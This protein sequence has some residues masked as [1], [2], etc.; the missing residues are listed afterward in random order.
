MRL[1]KP[2][3]F[4]IL[5]FLTLIAGFLVHRS[6]STSSFL[7]K[8]HFT[9]I[10]RPNLSEFMQQSELLF[11]RAVAKRREIRHL[12]GDRGFFPAKDENSFKETPWSIWDLVTPSYGCPWEM[13]RIGRV[14]EGG[15]WVCGLSRLASSKGKKQ[16]CVVYSFG[17][18]ND[19]SFEAELLAR[20]D[21]E[22]WGYDPHVPGFNF[23]PEVTAEMRGRTHFERVGVSGGTNEAGKLYTIQEL[24][25]RNGHLYIDLLKT[26]V[27]YSE[28]NTLSSLN[29]HTL[30]GAPG[31]FSSPDPLKPEFPI[32]Q[33]VVEM[34][35]FEWQGITASVFLDWWESMEYRGL[36]AVWREVDTVAV[37][38]GVEDGLERLCV[39]TLLNVQDSKNKLY[40]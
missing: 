22:I 27:E 4:F 8:F 12:F 1:S 31:A 20:T 37:G 25:K 18:G 5:A 9:S 6:N 10:S 32:G 2:T 15:W 14:G 3:Q 38:M 35:I 28:Y 11:Q 36:R 29:G 16:S 21:C 33:I 39:Y 23:G 26:D 40:H 30:P 19:S 34:H 17:I 24:M 7:P 13:E